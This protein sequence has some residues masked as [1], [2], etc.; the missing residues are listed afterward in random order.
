LCYCTE[1][2]PTARLNYQ[3]AMEG[4]IDGRDYLSFLFVSRGELKNYKKR[5]PN[6]VLVEL[7]IDNE[8]PKNWRDVYRQAIKIFSETLGVSHAFM[9]EDNIYC[10]LKQ[11]E[12]DITPVSMLEYFSFLQ[13][14]AI[15]T[16]S[17]LVGSRILNFGNLHPPFSTSEW[18]NNIVQSCFVVRTIDNEVNFINHNQPDEFDPGLI[19]FNRDCNRTHNV[20]QSQKYIL[21]C[22]YTMDDP[23]FEGDK[24]KSNF[25]TLDKIEPEGHGYNLKVKVLTNKKV[26]DETLSDGSRYARAFVTIADTS[27]SC[28]FIAI[29]DQIG[30]LR[31]TQ[32]YILRN[33]K[34]V[35]FKGFMRLEVDEWGKIEPYDGEITTSTKGK[36]MS[37]VEYELVK[38]NESESGEEGD[39]RDE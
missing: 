4:S 30:L 35:M 13:E 38:S 17:L 18:D 3:Q 19:Q 11:N 1:N 5:W 29:N 6:Q 16:Q 28:A 37:T 23:I 9:L 31:P 14:A 39:G 21:V 10:A 15:E 8:I 2:N 36:N 32:N 33:A 26:I 27:E 7:P 22:G 20:Q 12:G 24:R 25:K 34:V